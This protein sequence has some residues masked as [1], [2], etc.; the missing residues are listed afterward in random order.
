M[1][2]GSLKGSESLKNKITA[3]G[4][5]YVTKLLNLPQRT[6]FLTF[7]AFSLSGLLILQPFSLKLY[8][9]VH[10]AVRDLFITLQI[11]NKPHRFV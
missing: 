6:H 10:F 8:T 3:K 2:A 4:I 1:M 11:I 7:K 5:K 9:A